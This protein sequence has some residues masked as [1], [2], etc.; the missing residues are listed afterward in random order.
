MLLFLV[1]APAI[2]AALILFIEKSNKDFVLNFS[3]FWS[4]AVFNWALYLVLLFDPTNTQFQF[5]EEISWLAFS[6][7]SVVFGLDGLSLFM[8]VL[9]SFLI[10]VCI[11]LSRNASVNVRAKEFNVS[12]LVLESILFGVFATLDLMLF[13]FLFEAVLIPMYLLLGVC[14]SRERKIRAAYLLF[15]YTLVS[16]FFMFV[17]ILQLYFIFGTTDYQLLKT[18]HLSLNTERLC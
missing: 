4:L 16:S 6:G 18:F 5:V 2:G 3:L 14:G 11:T 12:F 7:I 13:Y 17:S 10:P 1:I 9:T 8:L 15:L